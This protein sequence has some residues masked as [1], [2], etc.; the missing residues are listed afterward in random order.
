[1]WKFL[2]RGFGETEGYSNGSI[3][4][5]KG[6]PLQAL[7][8]EVCQNS[9]D[10]ADGSGKPVIVEFQTS[11]MRI[12]DFPG[13]KYMRKV[14]DACADYWKTNGDINTSTF[15]KQAKQCLKSNTFTV[16]RISDYNTTGVKGAFSDEAIT[17]WGSLVKG[18]A[19]SVKTDMSNAA[20]SYGIGKAAPFVSSYEQAHQWRRYRHNG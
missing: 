20:G 19:F 5:F 10:A 14:I 16:L 17:P 9:L 15:L 4:E 1:M 12:D 6:N 13:M 3:A 2:S 11:T 8:R 18:N 7:A